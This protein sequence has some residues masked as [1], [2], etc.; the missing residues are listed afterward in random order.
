MRKLTMPHQAYHPLNGGTRLWQWG[1]NAGDNEQNSSLWLSLA[2][3]AAD[4]YAL[5]AQDTAATDGAGLQ[6]PGAP[7]A[8]AHVAA[9]NHSH[10]Q[11]HSRPLRS[12][13]VAA[14]RQNQCSLLTSHFHQESRIHSALHETSL[15][16]RGPDMYLPRPQCLWTW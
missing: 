9:G 8:H 7:S 13:L 1:S 14:S 6:P 11:Q 12:M 4:E 16:V 5:A 3:S 15:R 2:G 10:L